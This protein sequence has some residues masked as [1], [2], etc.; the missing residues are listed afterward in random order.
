MNISL[1]KDSDHSLPEQIY[2]SLSDRIKTGLMSEGDRLPSVRKLADQLHVSLVTV[3][4]AYELL[5]KKQLIERRHGK[6]SYVKKQ[7]EQQ[8]EI[9]HHNWQNMIVD[10]LPRAQ[11]WKEMKSFSNQLRYNLS[12]AN[13]SEEFLP[14]KE[15]TAVTKK[16][17]TAE[18]NILTTYGPGPG[19]K[20]IRETICEYLSHYGLSS[21]AD[22]VI[23]STGVQQGLDLVAKTFLNEGDVVLVEAPTYIGIIDLFKSRG[24]TIKTIPTNKDGIN[25]NVLLRL[26]EQFSPK[27]IYTN[28]TFQNPMGT[29]LPPK[30]R[31]R[32]IEIAQAF[33]VIVIEDDPWTELT[34]EG[35]AKPIK[36]MDEYGHVIYMRGFSK[37]IS[38][39]LRIGCIVAN[40]KILNKL[41]AAK[42]V[43]DLG[44]PL[45]NQR[46][47][48]RF[49]QTF[50]FEKHFKKQNSLLK[51][52]RNLLIQALKS[53][54]VEGVTWTVPKGG[55]VM[56]I[57]FPTHVNT[58]HL[59]L[60]AQK[61]ELSFLP[62]AMCYPND[63]EYH[64]LRISYG[65]LNITA[66]EKALNIFVNVTNDF[67]ES[68]NP[69]LEDSP[70]F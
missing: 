70:L 60:H 19:D 23:I 57:S 3:Q 46:I 67:M 44:S 31:R 2:L 8:E 55:P 59:L 12:L 17:I 68:Y 63:P 33:N 38:P 43:S 34:I 16:V 30:K 49:M 13:L 35:S 40:G 65:N 11:T 36:S 29:I 9:S 58:D 53:L 54:N 24:V 56:W 25:V 15:L 4:K 41:K 7:H 52:R 37:T 6:G 22:Q 32:L 66:F 21:T 27:L 20:I 64:H 45:L 50:N 10:Y 14:V 28:P 18:P 51:Y 69:Q 62:S 26:C 48:A 61:Q 1:S 5:E 39:G 47:L 42:S